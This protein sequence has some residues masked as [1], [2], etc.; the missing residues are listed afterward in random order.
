ML[1]R[2]C[3][4]VG[5]YTLNIRTVFKTLHLKKRHFQKEVFTLEQGFSNMSLRTPSPEY[6]VCFPYQTPT[7]H[8]MQTLLMS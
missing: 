7:I 4:F 6:F 8:V 2:T 3:L 5:C 1:L